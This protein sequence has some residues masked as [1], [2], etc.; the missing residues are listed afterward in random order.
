MTSEE[1]I[2][3][4][5]ISCKNGNGINEVLMELT[6]EIIVTGKWYMSKIYKD[7]GDFNAFWKRWRRKC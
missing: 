7:L 2:K 1:E 4:F 6:E 3:Y 5:E